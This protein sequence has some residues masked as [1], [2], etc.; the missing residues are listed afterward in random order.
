MPMIR[1]KIFRKNHQRIA[2]MIS[3]FIILKTI[4]KSIMFTL[5]EKNINFIIENYQYKTNFITN[6]TTARKTCNIDRYEVEVLIKTI[7]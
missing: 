6:Y 3:D 1:D 2:R 4:A 5:T 7:S